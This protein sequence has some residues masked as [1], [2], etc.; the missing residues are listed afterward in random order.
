M[1]WPATSTTTAN[2]NLR[3]Q[4]SAGSS[5]LTVMPRAGSIQIT[6][7]AVNGWFPVSYGGKTGFASAQYINPPQ[8]T[9]DSTGGTTNP[10]S[11]YA[12]STSNTPGTTLN[13]RSGPGTSNSVLGSIPHGTSLTITGAAQNGWIPVSYNGKTGYVS[14]QYVNP[15][16]P[17]PGTP[18]T[19]DPGTSVPPPPHVQ[20]PGSP[21]YNP[22]STYGGSQ[23]WYGT[24]IV[25][26]SQDFD[27]EWEKSITEQ[28]FGGFGAKANLARNLADRA[29][30]GFSAATMNNLNLDPRTYIN[31]SLGSDFLRNS[32]AAMTP[33]QRGEM[34]GLLQPRA[35]WNDR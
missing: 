29:K 24:P 7:P 25:E 26:Q 6:G 14:A 33:G 5:V 18:T 13:F 22:G 21:F 27:A 30:S 2:L 17:N 9:G 3:S 4:P 31:Q 16:T 34:P 15:F 8:T 19:P 23:N 28:G 10:T 35:R 11:P 1:A 32:M 20:Q 12:T